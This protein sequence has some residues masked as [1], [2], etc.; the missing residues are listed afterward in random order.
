MI[1]SKKQSRTSQAITILLALALTVPLTACKSRWIVS[2]DTA[3]ECDHPPFPPKPYTDLSVSFF[4]I[5]QS[6]AIDV[7]RALLGNEPRLK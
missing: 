2:N 1:K 3:N 7:C 6:K 4:I 5:D